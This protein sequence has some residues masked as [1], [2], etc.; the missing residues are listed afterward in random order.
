MKSNKSLK[1]TGIILVLLPM[2][3]VAL[4]VSQQE[5]SALGVRHKY[6]VNYEFNF[7]QGNYYSIKSYLPLDNIRQEASINEHRGANLGLI[8]TEGENQRIEWKG[9]TDHDSTISF[10]FEFEGRPLSYQIPSDIPYVYRLGGG[11]LSHTHATE[12]IQSDHPKIVGL[13]QKL[14]LGN[15]ALVD[16]IKSFYDFVYKIPSSSSS[17]LTDALMA[18]ENREASC[19]GKS[20]LFVALCR[21]MRI[22]ARVA[23]GLILEEASK[24]TSHLWAEVQIGDE[25]VPFDALNGHFAFLPGHYMELYKGDNFLIT[26]NKNLE[27]DYI[28][29]IKKERV[30]DYPELAAINVWELADEAGIPVKMFQMILLLPVGAFL[31]AIF[32]NIIG[33]KTYGV[34]LPVLIAMSWLEMGLLAGMALLT[35]L[36]AVVGIVNYPLE[37]WGVQFNSKISAMLM[38]VVIAALVAVKVLHMT[39]WLAASA[40]LF[41]PIII[42]TITSERVARKIE[43]EGFKASIELYG[44]T[45]LVA[46]LIYFVLASPSIQ[47][48]LLT[49]PEL[50]ISI[51]GFNLFLGKWI[52]LRLL[53]YRRFH[54]MTQQ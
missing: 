14:A 4:R 29:H 38:A 7:S 24:K 3:L 40:P 45:L 22:P 13:A 35:T 6:H 8:F 23:G 9:H 39:G 37:R 20:R 1:F 36:I 54:P 33:L 43:E 26:R 34:F 41:F 2:I 32:K 44:T 15:T 16:V 50:I 27:F 17:E 51:A 25:W 19:N 31:V 30:N 52:G 28:Y 11:A 53:E 5:D 10:H 12:L 18:L 42:L 21:S 47:N 46:T 48:L 49:F